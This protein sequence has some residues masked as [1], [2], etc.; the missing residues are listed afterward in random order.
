MSNLVTV[1]MQ[2][3]LLATGADDYSQAYKVTH[4]TGRPLVVFVGADWCSHCRTMKQNVLPQLARG[5]CLNSVAFATV[6]A[7]AQQALAGQLMKG[8]SRMPQLIMYT[9][10]DGS[11]TRT[12]M[13]GAKS[14]AE[15]QEFLHCGGATQPIITLGSR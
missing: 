12:E 5:G 13:T 11:W 3:S 10:T 1:L 8:G 7:D 9:K 2:F 15:V 14:V 6:D 4:E